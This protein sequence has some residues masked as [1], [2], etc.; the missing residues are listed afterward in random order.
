MNLK[1]TIKYAIIIVLK[2]FE[3]MINFE[4]F[5]YYSDDF[6]SDDVFFSSHNNYEQ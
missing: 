6:W 4:Y 1:K 5:S 3:R 2:I